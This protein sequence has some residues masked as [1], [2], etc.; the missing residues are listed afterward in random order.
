MRR[1]RTAEGMAVR[2]NVPT[3]A[4]AAP[5]RIKIMQA[6]RMLHWIQRQSLVGPRRSVATHRT[7]AAVAAA[8]GALVF[9]VAGLLCP[10]DPEGRPLRHGTHRQLGLPPCAML[11][12]TGIPC[13]TCGMT[14]SVS[15]VMHGDFATAL[16]VNWAGVVIAVIGIPT[17]A[18]LAFLACSGIQP[19]FAAAL[20]TVLAFMCL[21][22]GVAFA[23]YVLVVLPGL[24]CN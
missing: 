5:E 18:W 4:V 8:L 3:E 24:F 10:Y 11:T 2:S 22:V 15:L 20:E 6:K 17:V 13:T 19:P 9:V 1:F 14:T 7:L 21:S 23:R 16:D 12:L